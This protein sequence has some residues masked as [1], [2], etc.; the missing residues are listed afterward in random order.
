MTY[1]AE[2][3]ASKGYVVVAIDH[4]DSI[5]GRAASFASTLLNRPLDQLFVLDEMGRRSAD[6]DGFLSGL[7]AVERSAVVGYSMGGYGALN[8][9]G[10]GFSAS[11]VE[12]S[13]VPA[14]ALRQ[15]QAG[16]VKADPRVKAVVAIAPWG[17]PEA[18]TTIEQPGLS[19]WDEAG[20]ADLTAPTLFIAGSDD[21]VS[22]YRKGVRWLFDGAV[23]SDRYLLVYRHARHNIGANP[24]PAE[25][26][27]DLESFLRRAEPT[28]SGTRLNNLNQHFVTA[29]LGLHLKGEATR[30]YLE[31][32]ADGDWQG[33]GPRT[34]VGIE[35]LR[36]G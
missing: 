4:T 35:L 12:R 29:F 34:A 17:G 36:G 28:W 3:L 14:G 11:F 8:V 6:P 19:C 21:D 24:P 5:T 22:G 18:L 32:P 16:G 7:I 1:L 31:G 25:A 27:R 30:R 9:A 15:R 2:N 23:A 20:L 33:F 10:A 26:R 13:T